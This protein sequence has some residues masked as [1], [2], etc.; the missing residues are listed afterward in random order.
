MARYCKPTWLDTYL[1][2]TKCSE[3]P[4]VYHYWVALTIISAVLKRRVY[5][6][7]GHF[8]TFPNLYTFL[9]GP[10]GT[11]KS[12]AIKIGGSLLE[13]KRGRA[14]AQDPPHLVK[15][16]RTPELFISELATYCNQNQPAETPFLIMADEAASFFRRAKYAVDMIPI[17]IKFYD[18]ETDD[19][20]T[21]ARSIEEVK[22]PYG[23]M[24]CG[25]IP[26][27]LVD[28]MPRESAAGGFASRI[29]WVYSEDTSRCEP[30]PELSADFMPELHDKLVHDLN[31]MS[32]LSGEMRLTKS[33]YSWFTRWYGGIR[34]EVADTI[35]MRYMGYMNRKGETVYKLAML[36]CIAESDS[37]LI[38]EK[39]FIKARLVFET[40]EPD[41]PKVYKGTSGRSFQLDARD[42]VMRILIK[43][44]GKIQRA[45]LTR[46]CYNN[47]LSLAEME[48]AIDQLVAEGKI[49]WDKRGSAVVYKLLKDKKPAPVTPEPSTQ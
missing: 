47:R 1:R 21:I 16:F 6:D 42:I 17:L 35:D 49:D 12:A 20:G 4:E 7:R 44:K 28:I 24:L 45:H 25:V 37:L 41:L 40:L 46:A 38:R 33:A 29:I 18:C 11:R 27:I 31:E 23:T 22:D 43:S 32:K 15:S 3:A 8:E 9:V 36:L 26:E 10:S 19:S 30:H 14:G 2:F 5:K 13:G 48:A 39:H 34:R